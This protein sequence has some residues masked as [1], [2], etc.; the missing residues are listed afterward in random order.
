M[1]DQ[2]AP[3]VLI[4]TQN[5]W[6]FVADAQGLAGVTS[7]AEQ[8]TRDTWA[9]QY[10]FPWND[11]PN[12]DLYSSSGD[13]FDQSHGTGTA[14]LY[15]VATA[16]LAPTATILPSEPDVPATDP[17]P[18]PTLGGAVFSPIPTGGQQVTTLVPTAVGAIMRYILPAWRSG[19][20]AG[21]RFGQIGIASGAKRLLQ[22]ILGLLGAS[23]II[24]I[25]Q[26]LGGSEGD[27]QVVENFIN[28]IEEMEKAGIIHSYT[29]SRRFAMQGMVDPGPRYFVLDLENVSGWYTNFYMSR[30]S[31]QRHDEKQ[32]TYKRPK[33][34]ARSNRTPR[35]R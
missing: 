21:G 23:E 27:A 4:S 30:S 24:D 11:N 15:A 1:P 28:C 18:S 22:A 25:A 14:G 29:P 35:K 16:P 20:T 9:H 6:K 19:M 5:Q 33:T 7:L 26:S 32:D 10:P 34:A 12:I 31:L 3:P 8:A 13:S 2:W 17:D